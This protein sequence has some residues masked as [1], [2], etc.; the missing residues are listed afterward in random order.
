[1]MIN[2]QPSRELV[3]HAGNMTDDAVMGEFFCTGSRTILMT[4][5]GCKGCGLNDN[6]IQTASLPVTPFGPKA[7]G[8]QET[9]ALSGLLATGS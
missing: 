3:G 9:T 4:R 5:K 1:M 8:V 2:S 6:S 7:Q